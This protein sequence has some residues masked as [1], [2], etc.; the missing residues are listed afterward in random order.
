MIDSDAHRTSCSSET[1][2]SRQTTYAPRSVPVGCVSILVS[3]LWCT[4]LAV[5]PRELRCTTRI[6]CFC[7]SFPSTSLGTSTACIST[8]R[9]RW[10]SL[11]GTRPTQW[12]CT[13]LRLVAKESRWGEESARIWCTMQLVL[14]ASPYR[15]FLDRRTAA[16]KKRGRPGVRC[17]TVRSADWRKLLLMPLTSP[18]RRAICWETGI[19][20]V[21]APH[22]SCQFPPTVHHTWRS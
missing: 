9:P 10:S 7:K 21:S 4:W 14:S 6:L 3:C 22:M 16:A 12:E 17:Y 15:W 11:K 20:G 18:E 5:R 8:R 2:N 1:Y 13:A 19:A